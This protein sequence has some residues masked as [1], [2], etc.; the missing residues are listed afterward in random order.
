MTICMPGWRL[1]NSLT[2][3]MLDLPR[4]S[5]SINTTSGNICDTRSKASSE[6]AQV[7]T[8]WCS[9]E[10]LIIASSSSRTLLSPSTTATRIRRYWLAIKYGKPWQITAWNATIL[11]RFGRFSLLQQPANRR[12]QRA[13]CCASRAAR[14]PLASRIRRT[15]FAPESGSAALNQA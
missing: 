5:M 10:S 6:V 9:N 13:V 7:A 11:H 15:D 12:D 14:R 1:F 8:H 2:L 4:R 3:P